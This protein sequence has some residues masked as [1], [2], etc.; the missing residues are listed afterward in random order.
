[1][2]LPR[3]AC[4]IGSFGMLWLG[5]TGC[6]LTQPNLR[7]TAASIGQ[8]G[9]L[10]E[11][12]R[13]ALTVVI[14]T[15]PQ[16]D[17]ALN[18]AVWRVA[19]EQVIGP[20]LRRALESNGLRVGR[21][22]GDLPR[23]IVDLLRERPPN[24]PGVSTIVNPVGQS[25]LVDATQTA[26]RESVNI[27]LS[28]TDGMVK[29]K[30]YELAKGFLRLT[31]T[32]VGTTGVSVRV[33]PEVHFG[34]VQQGY[35][36]VPNTGVAAP[37][38]F[39][40]TQGQKEE[41]FRDLAT[42]LSLEPGQVAVI[43]TR[44]ERPGSLGDLIF[45]KP[46]DQSDRLLQTLVLIWAKRNESAASASAAPQTDFPAALLSTGPDSAQASESRRGNRSGRSKS[47]VEN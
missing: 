2:A 37:H 29:G 45:Q 43:G 38:E 26:P 19:D 8:S 13:C 12:K 1:M 33:T 22:S 16:H 27:L 21:I 18:E 32:Q 35:G 39:Q 7:R 15:R 30:P 10:V 11:A 14:L 34:P 44:P 40:I 25:T 5:S 46:E 42:T 6:D 36:M 9:R 28:Q 23:E 17:L 47:Q 3:L 24:Q 31:A 4:V 41:T 20:E